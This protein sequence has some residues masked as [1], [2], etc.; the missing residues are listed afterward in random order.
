MQATMRYHLTLVRMAIIKKFTEASLLQGLGCH[1]PSVRGPG[2]VLGLGNRNHMPNLRVHMP[3]LKILNAATK[4][5]HSQI[6][7]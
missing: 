4:T 2:S 1:V 5:Q 7:K 6:N 3:Q